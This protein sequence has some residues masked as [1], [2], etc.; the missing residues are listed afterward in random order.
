VPGTLYDKV[1]DNHVVRQLDDK[2]YQLF[3]GLHFVNDVTSAEAFASLRRRSLPVRFPERTV[4]TLD[5]ILPTKA[6]L[7][8]YAD[9]EA[10]AL[11]QALEANVSTTGISYLAP[12]SGNQG[13]IHVI[14]PELGLSQPGM[15]ICCGDS[16]TS[17]HGALGAVA[18]GIGTSQV[19]DVLA[20]QSLAVRRLSTRE[21]R[22]DGALPPGVGAKDAILAVIAR[23]GVGAGAGFAYEYTGEVVA[24]MTIDQRMTLCNM[25]IEGGAQVGCVGPDD[26]TIAYLWERPYAPRNRWDEAVQY[27]QSIR[28]DGRARFDDVVVIPGETI[29][30]MVTWGINPGQSVGIAGAIPDPGD[31][32]PNERRSA[33]EAIEYMGFEPGQPVAGLS[34]DVAF[35][36]SCANGR[37]EDVRSV[38][39]VIEQSGGTVASGVRALVVPGSERVYSEVVAAGY[40]EVLERA[41]FE[42]R[43][44]GCSMCVGMNGDAL[45]GREVCASTST[46]NFKGRQ[47]SATGRTLLMSPA[48]VAASAIAG[49]VVDVREFLGLVT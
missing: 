40:R 45:V 26:K 47:G 21:I 12:G 11:T 8:P 49:Q 29:E 36:G 48:M 38:V 28:S 41:G 31:L 46:R 15:T 19:R 30:P 32:P 10:E 24:A 5:H 44:P 33:Q 43:Q 25:S 39:E 35:V 27:W 20:T 18:F 3:I 4:S 7:R 42:L 16:H 37:L 17:T 1:F 9:A 23:L 2:L 22:I 14:G 13:I 6:P 34:I